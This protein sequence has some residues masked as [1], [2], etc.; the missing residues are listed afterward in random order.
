MS[1]QKVMVVKAMYPKLILVGSV[2]KNRLSK[3]KLYS[4]EF[5]SKP[6]RVQTSE[7]CSNDRM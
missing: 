2:K 7:T 1:F 3:G 4:K 6:P 5:L